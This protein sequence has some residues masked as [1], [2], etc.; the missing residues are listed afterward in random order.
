MPAGFK[1]K[2]YIAKGNFDFPQ[3]EGTI[4]LK[5]L[6]D[7]YVA[8]HLEESPLNHTQTLTPQDDGRIL[9]LAEVEDTAQLRWWVLA[10]GDQIEVAEPKE[11]RNDISQILHKAVGKYE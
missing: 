8:K 10:F 9:L 6:F 1:L 2:D 11:L 5:C 7:S 3:S 4:H